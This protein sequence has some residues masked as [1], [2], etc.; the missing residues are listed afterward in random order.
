MEFELSTKKSR[1][2]CSVLGTQH[3]PVPSQVPK[4]TQEQLA[5]QASVRIPQRPHAAV[6][7]APGMHTPSPLHRPYSQTPS[8]VQKRCCVPQRPHATVSSE[9][10]LLHESTMHAE[11]GA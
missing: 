2:T 4:G 6:R 10:G 3:A 9:P 7:V 1:S 8:E 5:S 11:A